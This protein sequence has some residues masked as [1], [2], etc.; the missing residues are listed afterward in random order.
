MG[1][2]RQHFVNGNHR[3]RLIRQMQQK[4]YPINALR[5]A[6]VTAAEATDT[7]NT[8]IWKP[9]I[10]NCRMSCVALQG[11][12]SHNRNDR[13]DRYDRYN[14]RVYIETRLKAKITR[15]TNNYNLCRKIE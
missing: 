6:A 8:T 13:N 10:L 4:M 14:Y 7:T 12:V 3:K 11:L 2:T 15:T 9:E 1:V 5:S